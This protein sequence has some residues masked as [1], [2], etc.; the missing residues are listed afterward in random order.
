MFYDAFVGHKIS[1]IVSKNKCQEIFLESA[2][3]S[4][5]CYF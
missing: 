3:V 5:V 2:Q 4:K 1:Y